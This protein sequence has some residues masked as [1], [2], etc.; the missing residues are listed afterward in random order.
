[1]CSAIRRTHGRARF[2][3]ARRKVSVFGSADAG[4]TQNKKPPEGGLHN[5]ARDAQGAYCLTPSA[6]ICRTVFVL[7]PY[8][9]PQSMPKSARSNVAVDSVPHTSRLSIGLMKHLNDSIF[10]FSGFVTPCSVSVP[11][12]STGVSPSKRIC[13]PL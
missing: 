7:K 9:L 11:I 10:R 12:T 4:V 8:D 2:A 13:V 5:L 1:M 3:D 6:W